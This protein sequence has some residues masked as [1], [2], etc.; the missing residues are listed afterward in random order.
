MPLTE[1]SATLVDL[2]IY[3]AFTLGLLGVFV[4]VL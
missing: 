1:S 3:P 2:A 4:G